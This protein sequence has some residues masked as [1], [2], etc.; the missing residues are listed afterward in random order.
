[1]IDF[2]RFS[3]EVLQAIEEA[4]R[5]ANLCH[6][7]VVTSCHLVGGLASVNGGEVCSVLQDY[8][9]APDQ[10]MDAIAQGMSEEPEVTTAG[11]GM[12]FH[13]EVEEV[14]AKA[15]SQSSHPITIPYVMGALLTSAPSL[16]NHYL[17]KRSSSVG[18]TISQ[19]EVKLGGQH[20]L[21]DTPTGNAIKQDCTNMLALAADGK[22]V[23]AI[24]RDEEVKRVLLILSRSTKNN[25]VW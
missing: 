9:F 3:P 8:G 16:I 7:H 12:S 6:S 10:S 4:A 18:K 25:F 15:S 24:G 2:S 17:V 1:M 11:D 21:G 19:A 20:E 23:H 22:L 5:K 14:F 13:P